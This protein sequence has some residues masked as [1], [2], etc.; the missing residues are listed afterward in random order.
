MRDF[1]RRR[2]L[3][4]VIL[5]IAMLVFYDFSRRFDCSGGAMCWQHFPVPIASTPLWRVPSQTH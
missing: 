1:L 2:W 4:L 5:A 3:L